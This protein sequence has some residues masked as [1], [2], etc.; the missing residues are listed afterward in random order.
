MRVALRALGFALA[1]FAAIFA[2][3]PRVC[4]CQEDPRAPT[5][6]LG[7]KEVVEKV[8][9]YTRGTTEAFDKAGYISLGPFLL[10]S[11]VQSGDIESQLAVKS[12]RWIETRHFRI[13]STLATCEVTTDG[14]EEKR[15]REELARLRKKLPRVPAM[16]DKLD[17]WLRA[18]LYAL[19]LE[20]C[21]ASFQQAF[22]LSDDD[23]KPDA[24]DK[25]LGPGPFLGMDMKFVTLLIESEADFER[26][27][28]IQ[29]AG[30]C[31]ASAHWQLTGD[32]MVMSATPQGVR[33][34]G[35]ATES[36]FTS[37][38]IYEQVQALVEGFR[39]SW[40]A[41]PPWFRCG[42][43][44]EF[45]RRIDKRWNVSAFGTTREFGDNSWD[46]EPRV[47]RIVA[48]SFA[49]PWKE[50]ASWET[51]NDVKAQAHLLAW[52]R[53][54]WILNR[55]GFDRRAFLIEL[56]GG[57]T[58][59]PMTQ[60]QQI[61]IDRTTSAF[62]AASSKALEDCDEDWKRDVQKTCARK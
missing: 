12:M 9:P 26:V 37:L 18:H 48:N 57:V 23:F 42:L 59:L 46:W 22:Q 29:N 14:W 53:V 38:V 36:A 62:W 5:G 7:E 19:R 41:M 51:W 2:S 34:L 50:M 31:K 47:C 21:Y 1:L 56:G 15:L 33:S 11:A 60:W 40:G 52:S 54:Q 55:K 24:D 58:H 17:P 28:K 13:G 3:A 32:A 27:L 6:R 35:F 61:R 4:A 45:S 10:G 30:V 39:K 49:T 25:R 43:G 44:F 8:D 16:V 20:E